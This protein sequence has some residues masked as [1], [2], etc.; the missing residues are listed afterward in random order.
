M[1]TI[2]VLLFISSFF[3]FSCNE[4]N[5]T[6]VVKVRLTDAP[7]EYDAVN[8]EI[9]NVQIHAGENED[10]G[11]WHNLDIMNPGIYNLLDFNNGLDTLLGTAELPAGN[12]SQMRLY[13]GENNTLV[14]DGATYNL[15][16]TAGER[17]G[18]KLLITRQFEPGVTYTMWIDFDAARS[19][20]DRGNGNYNL[21]P[22]IR[23]F[24]EATSGSIE[25]VIDPVAST[26][27]VQ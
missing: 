15:N 27:Y 24:T 3:I 26:P 23:V 20:V 13:L 5:D 19:V 7:G 21:K 8:V 6:V 1:K 10:E 17:S 16:T 22:V 9:Q 25:G 2:V 11:G 14:K 18:L 12:I 4:E